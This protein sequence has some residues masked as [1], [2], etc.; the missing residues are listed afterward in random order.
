M[1]MFGL[2]IMFMGTYANLYLSGSADNADIRTWKNV[3]QIV[4]NVK[5]PDVNIPIKEIIDASINKPN[6]KGTTSFTNLL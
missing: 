5:I 3:D 4:E 2:F 1:C 6:D